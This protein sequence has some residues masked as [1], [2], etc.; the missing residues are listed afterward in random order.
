[1]ERIAKKD[2]SRIGMAFFAYLVVAS[3]LQI[4]ISVVVNLVIGGTDYPTW[5][6]WVVNFVPMYC[7]ALPIFYL[8]IK[9]VPRE[10][11]VEEMPFSVGTWFKFLV[12]SIFV[13]IVGN[14]LSSL[15][16]GILGL[17]GMNTSATV[18]T[19]LSQ[20]SLI[21][22]VILAVVGPIVEEL[23]CRK[24]LIDRMH[25]YGG[26]VAVVTSALMFGL[27]HGN[28]AQ[29]F[30]AFFLG[31]VWGYV[32]YKTGKIIYTMLMHMTINF[33]GG[34]IAPFLLQ[35]VD[36]TNPDVAA[37]AA[38]PR[39]A[40][41]LIYEVVMI[42]LAVLGLVLF[43]V[44]RKNIAFAEERLELPKEERVKSVWGNVGMILFLVSCIGLFAFGLI[45]SLFA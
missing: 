17:L 41:F 14:L 26:S 38:S 5:V 21:G 30:Y 29:F 3:A 36:L 45:S 34:V 6:F 27:F 10:D 33:C 13:M 9:K 32:Y 20:T 19:L 25:V 44:G 22:N 8:I 42:T 24:W 12:I 35:G 4:G 18:E 43:L 2:F 7:V 28:F 11:L 40:G 23:I 37:L 1:M 39:F 15:V 16:G 31:L